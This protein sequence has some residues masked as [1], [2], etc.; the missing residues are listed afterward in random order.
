MFFTFHNLFS[1]GQLILILEL[2]NPNDVYDYL[3]HIALKL[4]ADKVSEV[5]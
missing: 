2:H 3:M 4:C 5:Q 1:F